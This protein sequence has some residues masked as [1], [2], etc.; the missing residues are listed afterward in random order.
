MDPSRR[1]LRVHA[2]LALAALSSAAC[3]DDIPPPAEVGSAIEGCDGA[4]LLASPAALSARGVFAVGARTVTVGALT[5]EVWYPAPAASTEGATPARY[6]IRAALPATE[7]AKISD[8]DNPWQVCDCIRDLPLDDAHGPYPVIVFVHGTAAFRHQSLA[9]VTHW[10][11]RGFVVIAA[12]HPGL[13]LRD[14]IGQTCGTGTVPQDLSGNIDA[15]LAAV[16]AP[17]G[18]LAFLAGHVDAARVAV[19]GHSAGAGAAAEAVGKPGVEVVISMAGNGAV[20]ASPTLRSTLFLAG[21]SDGVVSA[22][23]ARTAFE[24]SATPRRFVA[25]TDAGHL[26]FSD[27][28]ATKNADGKDLITIAEETG[29]CGAS[30]A[31]FLFDCDPAYIDAQLGWDIINHA[32]TAVLESTLQCQPDRALTNLRTLFPQVADLIE[33]P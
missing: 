16:A 20:Q 28:C 32:S 23:Q 8:A 10:A 5:A 27:L 26:A 13:M 2:A 4:A 30:I 3:G 7:A 15:L 9:L 11:S 6:D 22:G 25:I 21:T 12:D 19:T 17:Q 31:R 18:E 29:V 14:L 24:A 33:A 1:H